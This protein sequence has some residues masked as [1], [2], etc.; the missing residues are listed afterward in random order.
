MMADN[1]L[2]EV[3]EGLNLV[4]RGK[5]SLSDLM[6]R[7]DLVSCGRVILAIYLAIRHEKWAMQEFSTRESQHPPVWSAEVKN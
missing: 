6:V 4:V 2:L 1:S 3:I 5:K 7:I